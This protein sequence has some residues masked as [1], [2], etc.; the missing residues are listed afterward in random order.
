VLVQARRERARIER[1]SMPVITATT[2]STTTRQQ[3]CLVMASLPIERDLAGALNGNDEPFGFD[4]RNPN[5]YSQNVA[6]LTFKYAIQTNE[7]TDHERM[8]QA[9]AIVDPAMGRYCT[10]HLQEIRTE[11]FNGSQQVAL[12]R[13]I[14]HL[15]NRSLSPV[16]QGISGAVS[17]LV[18]GTVF[19]GL[20]VAVFR[21]VPQLRARFADNI[22]TVSVPRT[23]ARSGL[24]FAALI[25]SYNFLSYK[26]AEFRGVHD[27]LNAFVGGAL[28]GKVAGLPMFLRPGTRA[29]GNKQLL[30][31]NT[32]F[33]GVAFA[34]LYNPPRPYVPPFPQAAAVQGHDLPASGSPGG[35]TLSA[36]MGQRA[37]STSGR[38]G[39]GLRDG[40]SRDHR[41]RDFGMS[42]GG[43]PVSFKDNSGG[44]RW[45]GGDNG[46]R[47]TT[48]NDY[49]QFA[50]RGAGDGFGRDGNSAGRAPPSEMSDRYSDRF[51]DSE[52]RGFDQGSGAADS[53]PGRSGYDQPA[54]Y[55]QW[56]DNSRA[57]ERRDP[58]QGASNT[59]RDG[60]RD[61]DGSGSG[62]NDNQRR[63]SA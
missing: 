1:Q 31:S 42:S 55:D 36:A 9:L 23:M 11:P 49:D 21:L 30:L 15:Y 39:A 25:G 5:P 62:S 16:I 28:I 20:S 43:E 47:T 7:Q 13:S 48:G 46:G 12:N 24:S 44:D 4:E 32:L 34:F 52:G 59:Y 27:Y 22:A 17:G 57:A 54:S 33:S 38:E 6:F 51:S 19:G 2:P 29:F 14:E 41:D 50:Y 37:D 3:T 56:G 60:G 45:P 61:L 58:R 40:V 10:D 26:V 63:P 8:T 35:N 53:G 18:A